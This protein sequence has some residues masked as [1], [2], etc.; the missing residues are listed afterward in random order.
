M[1]KRDCFILCAW[2]FDLLELNGRDLRAL[3]LTKRRAMLR[4]VILKA[5][6]DVLP[7]SEDLPTLRS[8]SRRGDR[9]YRVEEGH[10][11]VCP[12]DL[13]LMDAS[14]CSNSL[15]SEVEVVPGGP[16]IS[17]PVNRKQS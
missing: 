6:D 4:E 16:R 2:C 7:Y 13:N 10:P 8:C 12:R 1:P 3:P 14:G 17:H 9:G 11:A 5:D 15:W